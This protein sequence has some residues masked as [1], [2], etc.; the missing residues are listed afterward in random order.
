MDS[1]EVNTNSAL[2]LRAVLT[3]SGFHPAEDASSVTNKWLQRAQRQQPLSASKEE[4]EMKKKLK[5]DVLT[6]L[7]SLQNELD[8]TAWMYS[9]NFKES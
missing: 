8:A 7:R 6:N 2:M 9:S 5:T 4:V 1:P 3:E